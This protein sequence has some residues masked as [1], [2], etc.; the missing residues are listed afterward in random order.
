MEDK[1]DKNFVSE[2][3][4]KMNSFYTFKMDESKLE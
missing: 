3:K 4:R 1:P 2:D